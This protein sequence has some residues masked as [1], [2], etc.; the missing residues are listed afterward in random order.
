MNHDQTLITEQLQQLP[1]WQGDHRAISVHYQFADF[2]Q[3]MAYMQACISDI[4]GQGHHPDWRN[5][6][7]NL[8]ISLCTHDAGDVVT[9]KDFALAKRLHALAQ[10]H[11]AKVV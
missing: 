2:V 4:E 7:N 10:E 3:A 6:Y 5:V 9:D 8:H 11:G 1:G